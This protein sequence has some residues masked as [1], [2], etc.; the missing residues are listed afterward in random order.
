MLP[1]WNNSYSVYN[2]KIDEQHKKLFELAAGIEQISDKSVSKSEVKELLVGFFNYMKEHFS[3][4]EEYMQAISYPELDEHKLIHKDIIRMMINLIKTV[5]TTNDLKEK[6]YIAAKKWLLNHI[7]YEDMKVA[8]WRRSSLSLDDGGEVS[9]EEEDMTFEEI[10][11]EQPKMYLYVCNCNKKLH[12]VPLS[13]HTKV[14]NQG[15][16]FRCKTCGEVI[17]FHKVMY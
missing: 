7:L 10:E 9:F 1:K 17:V 14:Q 6:L 11:E 16:K 12:D 8:K 4:E 2:T 5:K 3:D 15:A 13:V